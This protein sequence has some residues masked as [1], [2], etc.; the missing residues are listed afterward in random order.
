MSQLDLLLEAKALADEVEDRDVA[1]L[2][3]KGIT[4]LEGHGLP[5]SGHG[6]PAWRAGRWAARFEPSDWEIV[7]GC[8]D[9]LAA[10]DDDDVA[11]VVAEAGPEQ[12]TAMNAAL[13]H[14]AGRAAF[15]DGD[16]PPGELQGWAIELA[17]HVMRVSERSL[18]FYLGIVIAARPR[19]GAGAAEIYRKTQRTDSLHVVL[20]RGAVPDALKARRKELLDRGLTVLRNAGGHS[21]NLSA[22]GDQVLIHASNDPNAGPQS[23][24]LDEMRAVA[25]LMHRTAGALSVAVAIGS[26]F[27]RI[28]PPG[29]AGGGLAALEQLLETWME[30][31]AVK[32]SADGTTVTVQARSPGPIRFKTLF[33]AAGCSPALIGDGADTLRC[34]VILIDANAVHP[35]VLIEM[36]M[37]PI[38]S[39]STPPDGADLEKLMQETG[40]RI[41]I[42]GASLMVLDADGAPD[43]TVTKT[44]YGGPRRLW[45]DKRFW[46]STRPS[47]DATQTGYTGAPG[48]LRPAVLVLPLWTPDGIRLMPIGKPLPAPAGGQRQAGE[49]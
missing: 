12:A 9:W 21:A 8:V 39:K 4:A 11:A 14:W 29:E 42:D 22:D 13:R 25:D 47:S 34:E 43:A 46:E 31:S 44:N 26:G 16:P 23:W 37:P 10:S 2:I 35:P 28:L 19:P 7:V 18:R 36:P 1:T 32:A 15:G 38:A 41:K 33:H 5:G 40:E 3:D 49:N 27:G 48:I 20:T 24:T 30:W 17:E 45:D 6:L